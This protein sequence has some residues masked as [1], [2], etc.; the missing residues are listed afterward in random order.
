MRENERKEQEKWKDKKIKAEVYIFK[1]E[2]M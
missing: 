1:T 2:N